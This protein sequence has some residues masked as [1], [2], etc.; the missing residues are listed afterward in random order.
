MEKASRRIRFLI[1]AFVVTALLLAPVHGQLSPNFYANTCPSV[2]TTVNSAVS[3]ALN[4][5]SRAGAKLLRLFFHDC[6]C[7][8]C[9]ASILLDDTPTFQGEQSAGP[10]AGSIGGLD[11]IDNIKTSLETSC[12]G[13]VS[14]ADIIAIAAR[15][16]V[17]L[18]GGPNWNVEVGRRDSLAASLSQAN[19]LPGPQLTASQ[20]ISAFQAKGL[21]TNDLVALSG[22]HTFG[23]AQCSRFQS[24]LVNFQNTGAPDPSMDPTFRTSLQ[25]TCPTASSTLVDLDQ[26]TPLTFDAQYYQNLLINRGLMT[27]DQTLA[28]S[29]QTS[30][31]VNSFTSQSAFFNQ[32]TASMLKMGRIGVLTGNQGE[33]RTQCG[34]TN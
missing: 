24:R 1:A 26:G 17:A 5:D 3:S 4:S 6:F 23:K 8:G 25:S 2:F 30:G 7:L 20:L 10:N 12:P 16:G 34:S 11:I 31:L 32:F 29:G 19:N 27:S 21:N 14:C 13:T 9:D 18:A 22:A 33:I 28:T 15:D